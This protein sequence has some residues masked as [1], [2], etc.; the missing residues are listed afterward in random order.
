M[1]DP[2][3]YWDLDIMRLW[4]LSSVTIELKMINLF[5]Y[6]ENFLRIKKIGLNLFL[7]RL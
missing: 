5:H 6:T 2:R 4:A 1:F 3:C 7:P